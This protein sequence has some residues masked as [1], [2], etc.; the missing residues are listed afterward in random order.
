MEQ[1]LD[2]IINLLLLLLTIIVLIYFIST[3]IN[4][5]KINTDKL[6]LKGK[7]CNYFKDKK[8]I[9]TG[10]VRNSEKT[11]YNSILFLYGQIIPHFKD[12]L[13]LVYEN[14]SNDA[15]REILLKQS[16]KDPKFKVMCGKDVE[17]N[18]NKC[19]LNLKVTDKRNITAMRINKMAMLRNYYVEEIKKDKY[20]DYEYIIVYDFDLNPIITFNSMETTS[21]YF[22]EYKDIDAIC[23]NTINN[24]GNY[25][26]NYAYQPLGNTSK[27]NY[28]YMKKYKLGKTGLEKVNSCFNGL[29]I[30]KR[31]PF[32]KS[33]YYTYKM[34]SNKIGVECEHVGFNHN[35]NIYT[36]NDFVMI[37]DNN[38]SISTTSKNPITPIIKPDNRNPYDINPYDI[39]PYENFSN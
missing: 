36:N 25:Y 23:A 39:N 17:E 18:V 15:T 32:I 31:N 2:L 30:Y 11:L 24:K 16:Q 1:K 29:T 19:E 3:K 38:K 5:I 21:S 4:I 10:L 8:I 35:L 12:Y 37:F 26:D 28:D 33:L 13:I 7:I 6:S 14:D 20:K 27:Y 9:I 34:N 22:N